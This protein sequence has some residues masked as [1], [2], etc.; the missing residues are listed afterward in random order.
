MSTQSA[1]SNTS[2]GVSKVV[3][4]I[5]LGT[6]NSC[7][8]VWR[9]GRAE[10]IPNES[11]FNTTPSIVAFT[12]TE[13]LIGNSAKNQIAMN[14]TNTIFDAKRLIGRKFNDPTVQN[15]IKHFPFSVVDDGAN[16]PVFEVM[17]K[18]EK[19]R[20]S[21]IEISSMILQK[22]KDIAEQF[23]GEKVTRA[24][25]TVPA[26]FND[27]QRQATK[28]AAAI[29]GLDCLRI[30]N[31]PTASALAYGLDSV[32]GGK[33]GDIR[34]HKVLIFDCGGGTF[35]VSVLSLDE[36][37][38]EVLS[39]GGDTH[40]GGEDFDNLMVDY[41]KD[42]FKKKFAKDISTN[43]RSLRRLRTACENAKKTLSTAT[44]ASIE[45]DS[46]FE[47]QD[48]YTTITRAKF[49]DLCI[50]LFKDCMIPVEKALADANVSKAEIDEIVLVGGSTRIPKIQ[51][52]LSDMF[53]GKQLN[54]S[55]N[56]DEVVAAGAA[57]Q[58]NILSGSA[59]D[60]TK[61]ILL[62][63]VCPLSLGVA[64]RGEI[65]TNI[66]NRN[67][68]IPCRKTQSFT[69]S[70]AGQTSVNVQIFEG[71]RQFVRDNRK[72]GQFMLEGIPA[73]LERPLI[74]I[75]YDIDANGILN[76]SAVEKSTGKSN[77]IT[78]TNDKGRLSQQ[79]IDEMIRMAE[80]YA[81]QDKERMEVIQARNMLEGLLLTHKSSHPEIAEEGLRWLS[82]NGDS[83]SV[84]K[85]TYQ[86]KYK[87]YE[88]RFT[89]EAPAAETP[90]EG[91]EG[92][93]A[94]ANGEHGH[95]SYK[96][97]GVHQDT[98]SEA[99]PKE[100]QAKETQAKETQAKE[101]QAK[102]PSVEEVD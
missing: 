36:G 99:P 35:D 10:I 3:I 71:E 97:E 51:Q 49:E 56:P 84:S 55:V 98:S 93:D 102:K 6:T 7:V 100:T 88:A 91:D 62:L 42:E 101:T 31:E 15:D 54:K 39:T 27:A 9:G 59:D 37:I 83:E 1:S 23:L 28:D 5:D 89:S 45:I 52:L 16:Q 86:E 13:R 22:M 57:V 61:D 95:R 73:N 76:V 33:D 25:V 40:L 65:M 34:E 30:I 24:V 32:R 85:E 12:E 26:Y 44:Q 87:E 78:I 90:D 80:K 20:F 48:F 75:T 38:F 82:D 96:S 46:L 47:G 67:T 8:S 21:P 69:T 64:T 4:G 94:N 50:K 79:E 66:I 58:G 17:F 63:D 19:K 81:E 74:E 41:L 53:N 70:S 14:P 11:G 72:L 29:A 60:K 92:D 68:T 77:S 2:S 43:P 18:G